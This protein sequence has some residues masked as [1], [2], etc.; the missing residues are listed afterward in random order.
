VCEYTGSLGAVHV[1]I[2]PRFQSRPFARVHC[3]TS[4]CPP[5]AAH[6]QVFALMR[7]IPSAVDLVGDSFAGKGFRPLQT[8]DRWPRRAD[9]Q[10][11]RA[12]P[13]TDSRDS[14]AAQQAAKQPSSQAEHVWRCVCVTRSMR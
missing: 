12:Q 14:I 6:V 8:N 1:L 7:G 9:P 3:N 5:R 10:Q 4:K 11:L 13:A 2:G